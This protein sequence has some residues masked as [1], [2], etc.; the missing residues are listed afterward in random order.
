MGFSNILALCGGLGLFLFGM[1]YMGAGLEL[2]AGPKLNN[3]LEM[4]L[5][6]IQLLLTVKN[7]Q[8]LLKVR[9]QPLMANFM[10]SML[11]MA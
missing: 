6:V 4:L 9:K 7:M 8:L 10:I 1:K 5:T 3:L 11:K 2:A